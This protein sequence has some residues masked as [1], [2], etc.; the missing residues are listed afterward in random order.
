M[1]QFKVQYTYAATIKYLRRKEK[2]KQIHLH[3]IM[4]YGIISGATH[5]TVSTFLNYK[6]GNKNNHWIWK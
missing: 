3:N 4:S 5:L 1:E 6:I 2:S